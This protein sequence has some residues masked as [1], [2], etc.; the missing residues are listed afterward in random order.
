MIIFLPAKSVQIAPNSV[1]LLSEPGSRQPDTTGGHK[2]RKNK[3]G[4]EQRG[5]GL[6]F[7]LSKD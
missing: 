2:R 6:V 3:V 4:G 1:L 7:V 5:E